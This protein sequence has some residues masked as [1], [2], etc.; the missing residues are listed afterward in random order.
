V[1]RI[2]PSALSRNVTSAP[3]LCVSSCRT[4]DSRVA[5]C[6]SQEAHCS[7]SCL[8]IGMVAAAKAT[9]PQGFDFLRGPETTPGAV[10]SLPECRRHPVP[11]A[12]SP[13]RR[14][15]SLCS[16][17]HLY[18]VP[19][20]M[21]LLDRCWVTLRR[22]RHGPGRRTMQDPGYGLPRTTLPRTSV[23]RARRRAEAS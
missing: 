17:T 14:P 6:L 21:V 20:H 1:H 22:H 19:P 9:S 3:R 4:H 8:T 13:W 5:I 2:P 7:G 18:A 15:S 16:R 12:P 11:T 10:Q 23:N